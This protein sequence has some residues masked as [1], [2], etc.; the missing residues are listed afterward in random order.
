MFV[1]TNTLAYCAQTPKMLPQIFYKIGLMFVIKTKS[2]PQGELLS[3]APYSQTLDQSE[4]ACQG[5]TQTY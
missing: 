4:K 5:Q 1:V 3:G 2:L